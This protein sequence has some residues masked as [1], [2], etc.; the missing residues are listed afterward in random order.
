[1]ST[2]TDA[3]ACRCSRCGRRWWR[4]GSRSRSLAWRDLPGFLRERAERY[5]DDIAAGRAGDVRLSYAQLWREGRPHPVQA[6]WRSG[7]QPGERVLVQL[8]NTAGFIATVCGLFRAGLVP[9]YALPRTITELVTSPTRRP[10]PTSLHHTARWL[11]SSRVGKGRCRPEVPA[12][13]HVVIDGDAAGSSR[14]RHCRAA[15]QPAAVDPDPQSVAFR[16]DFRRQLG[17]PS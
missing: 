5:A 3:S 4:A 7:L 8:G 6:C 16:T 13:R 2:S 14:W 12:V 11:R 1:M 9:M 17:C 15:S 10:V